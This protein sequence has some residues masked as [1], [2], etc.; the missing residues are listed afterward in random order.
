MAVN[1]NIKVLE[2]RLTLGAVGC[3]DDETQSPN[4]HFAELLLGPVS[5]IITIVQQLVGKG[6][7]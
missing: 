3:D 5:R 1:I 2:K 6:I 7:Y 4:E